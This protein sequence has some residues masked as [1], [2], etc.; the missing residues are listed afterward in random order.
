MSSAWSAKRTISEIVD[1]TDADK[2]QTASNAKKPRVTSTAISGVLPEVDS[3]GPLGDT[4]SID[5]QLNEF[6]HREL[7]GLLKAL[8]AS[9]PVVRRSIG[10][11]YEEKVREQQA[12]VLS[13]DHYSKSV[14]RRINKEHS[15]LSGSKQYEKAF[16]VFYDIKDDIRNIAQQAG[17]TASDATRR[18]ALEGL[19]KVGKTVSL[20]GGDTLSHEVK[21]HFQ[22]DQEMTDAML[23]VVDAMSN[24]E[25]LFVRDE[26]SADGTRAWIATLEELVSLSELEMIFEDLRSVLVALGMEREGDHEEEEDEEEEDEEEEEEEEGEDDVC[27]HTRDNSWAGEMIDGCLCSQHSALNT[28][29]GHLIS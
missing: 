28:Q 11:L 15:S 8:S 19:R 29:D 27:N 5:D 22:G 2:Q 9:H 4:E 7:H 12:R 21:K 3:Q 20:S 24:E 13:F 25:R 16:D 6:T 26:W 17:R 18:N 1:L 14:W 10:N 23:S